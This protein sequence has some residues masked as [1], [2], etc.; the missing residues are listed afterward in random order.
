[1]RLFRNYTIFAHDTVV[2]VRNQKRKKFNQKYFVKKLRKINE[3]L[4][5][6]L[7]KI[8][9]DKKKKRRRPKSFWSEK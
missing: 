3:A 1:M 6:E 5:L 4:D 9:S 2:A 8:K 7:A